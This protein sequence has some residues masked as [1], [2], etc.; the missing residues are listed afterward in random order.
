MAIDFISL[1]TRL[2]EKMDKKAIQK[3]VK[4]L[5]EDHPALSR[6]ELCKKIIGKD[7]ILCGLVGAGTGALPGVFSWAAI[8][9]DIAN[10][11]LKQS[12]VVLSIACIYDYDPT[13][14]ERAVEVLACMGITGGVVAG[15]EQ[16]KH[17]V[18]LGLKSPLAKELAKKLGT[19]LSRQL[20]AKIIPFVGAVVGGALNYAGVVSVGKAAI[21]YYRNMA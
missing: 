9:P 13:M 20:M 3:N 18:K 12:Y 21:A 15:N 1:L 5:K 6:E 14:E 17:L 7:A 16:I 10:L 4:Q 2:I 8:A 19:V 11:L